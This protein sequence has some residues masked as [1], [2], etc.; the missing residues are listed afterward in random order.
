MRL[1]FLMPFFAL[2]GFTAGWAVA[3]QPGQPGSGQPNRGGRRGSPAPVVR[4]AWEYRT[5]AW[6]AV[7][8]LAPEKEKDRITAG[9]NKLGAE[10]WELVAVTPSPAGRLEVV[11]KRQAGRTLR[12]GPGDRPRAAAAGPAAADAP[13]FKIYRLRNAKAADMERTLSKILQA[14]GREGGGPRLALASDERTNS[15]LARAAPAQ[16]QEIEALLSRLDT[17]DGEKTPARK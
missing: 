8:G 12:G 1:R 6:S 3:Q 9:L 2:A 4:T 11:F 16:L 10:G 14:G 17:P 5:L 15:L 13:E 7:E